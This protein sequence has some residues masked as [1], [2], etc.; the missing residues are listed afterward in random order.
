MFTG[1][2]VSDPDYC[3]EITVKLTGLAI[4]EFLLAV[5]EGYPYWFYRCFKKVKPTTSYQS[6]ARYFYILRKLG[7]IEF[8]REEPSNSRFPRKYFRIVPGRE[9]DPAWLHPQEELYPETRIGGK[10]Y[11]KYKEM[12]G[13]E[14]L[15]PEELGL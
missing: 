9:D 7:L 15:P 10:R 2:I 14:T 11:R 1:D 3:P 8:V 5:G 13:G 12:I 4:R 6:V